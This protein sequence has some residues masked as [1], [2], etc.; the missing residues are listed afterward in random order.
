MTKQHII[1]QD[2]LLTE[3]K[4]LEYYNFEIEIERNVAKDFN[5]IQKNDLD[6]SRIEKEF[7]ILLICILIINFNLIFILIFFY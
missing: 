7:G 6:F 1:K 2:T 4:K 5:L 3:K